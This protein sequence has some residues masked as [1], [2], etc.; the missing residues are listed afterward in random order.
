VRVPREAAAVGQE[1]GEEQAADPAAK[2]LGA[3]EPEPDEVPA[4]GAEAP[5]GVQP[6]LGEQATGQVTEAG[7]GTDY[8]RGT[9]DANGTA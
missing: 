2:V 4:A 3:P 6:G 1:P 7:R 8:A 9:L 5:G